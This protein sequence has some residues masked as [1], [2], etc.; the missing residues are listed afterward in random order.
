MFYRY[1]NFFLKKKKNKRDT[2]KSVLKK[3]TAGCQWF[4][5]VT[6]ATWEA[7]IGRI[8]VQGQPGKIV[9]KT[10]SPK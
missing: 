10:P 5:P 3:I 9:C 2:P 6:L 4:T 1:S 7:E 8:M